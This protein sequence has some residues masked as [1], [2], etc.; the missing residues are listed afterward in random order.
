MIDVS[1]IDYS[2]MDRPEVLHLLFHP[3]PEWGRSQHAEGMEEIHVPVEGEITLGTRFFI[4]G[5]HAPN[6]VFFHGNGEIVADY[7]EVGEL[8]RRVGI[9]FIPVDY[10]GYGRSTGQPSVTAMM[11]DSHVLFHFFRQLLSEKGYD[12]AILIMG[13]S[14]GSASALELASTYPDSI[15]GI[16]I[17]SGFARTGPLMALLGL[18]LERMGM[19]EEE[20]FRN[21]EKIR[22]F[23]KPTLIIHGEFDELIPLEEGRLLYEAS[24]ASEKRLLEIRGAGHNDIF[25][26]GLQDYMEGVRNLVERVSRDR[27]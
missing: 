10:R 27:V 8:Y 16:V 26:V 25:L 1:K 4:S 18:P 3:R 22:L 11:R 15:D 21:W 20:G 7:D 13:R 23:P 9:N 14:L 6:I 24:G 19:T 5:L 17:E 2:V 12:G